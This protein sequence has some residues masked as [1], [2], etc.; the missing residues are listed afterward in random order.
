MSDQNGGQGEDK[1]TDNKPV[2]ELD[3]L[4]GRTRAAAAIKDPAVVIPEATAAEAHD[5]PMEEPESEA[6]APEAEV[7]APEAPAD[8]PPRK[9][10]GLGALAALVGV[11]VLGAGGYYGW[12]EIGSPPP[13]DIPAKIAALLTPPAVKPDAESTNEK[14]A[15]A[16][17]Q[18]APAPSAASPGEATQKAEAESSA[19]PAPSAAPSEEAPI[20][21][22]TKANAE[23]TPQK[24]APPAAAE[25]EKHA[26]APPAEAPGAGEAMKKAERPASKEETAAPRESAAPQEDATLKENSASSKNAA[27]EANSAT[28]GAA[29]ST[30]TPAAK[31]QGEKAPDDK[32]Q[33]AQMAAQLAMTQATV[34]QLSQKLKAV[35]DQL[36]APKPDTGDSSARL[37]VAQSLLTAIRQGDD[38]APMLNALQNFGDDSVRLAQLR[39]GLAAP[40]ARKLAEEFAGLAPRLIASAAPHSPPQ[41]DT[42]TPRNFGAAALAYIEAR[43]RQVVRIRP[44]GAPDKD[45][46]A[47]RVDRI[48]SDLARDD[49]AAA[50]TERTQLP[51]PA[52]A[53]S[54]DW[55]KTAQTRLEA[56]DAAKAEVAEALQNLSKNK[57]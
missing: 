35:E 2:G 42:R 38:Y 44:A 21:P 19:A 48:E 5:K 10:S 17:T 29:E 46:N 20:K 40:S 53:L 7:S 37:V 57:S 54:A 51:A 25:P 50:L 12:T 8:E 27:V 34:E 52:L 55:A 47:A 49:I 6:D 56:E 16:E 1:G 15:A 9:S 18:P 13:S 28:T 36:A 23:A 22:E 11:A 14:P 41:T 30:K 31:A 32:A 33:V 26:A 39:A 3:A 4:S 24:T 43:A 45:A